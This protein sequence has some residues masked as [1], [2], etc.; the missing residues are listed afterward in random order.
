[1]RGFSWPTP[2]PAEK[3]EG[4][5]VLDGPCSCVC[6]NVARNQADGWR[7]SCKAGGYVRDAGSCRVPD[8]AT[9]SCPSSSCTGYPIPGAYVGFCCD[10][11]L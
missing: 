2:G 11:R 8:G 3:L 5:L 4:P 10:V 6:N 9:W 7:G 1:M